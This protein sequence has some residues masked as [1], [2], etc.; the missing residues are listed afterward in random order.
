[1]P[2]L[3]HKQI[4]PARFAQNARPRQHGA[5]SRENLTP[6][7][8]SRISSTASASRVTSAPLRSASSKIDGETAAGAVQRSDGLSVDVSRSR[9]SSAPHLERLGP[10]EH[11]GGARQHAP[12]NCAAGS[13]ARAHPTSIQ[14]AEHAI[15]QH[16]RAHAE[17]AAAQR[18]ERAVHDRPHAVQRSV[19]DG[20][21]V[22]PTA[23][24]RAPQT[25]TDGNRHAVPPLEIQLRCR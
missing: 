11:H 1:M 16:E 18:A 5:K 8:I 14:R 7:Q 17:H 13:R 25:E 21:S 24:K 3:T 2:S 10:R 6:T 9:L 20:S 15:L 23:I 4:A 19:V 12:R 22:A